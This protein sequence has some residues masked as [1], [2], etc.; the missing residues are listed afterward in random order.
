MHTLRDLFYSKTARLDAKRAVVTDS[1]CM[2]FLYYSSMGA[3]GAVG[4]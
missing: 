2:L 3:T 1:Y 4:M